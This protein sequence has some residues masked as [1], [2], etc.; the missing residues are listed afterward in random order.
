MQRMQ[1]KIG[2]FL[3]RTADDSQVAILIADFEAADKMLETLIDASKH[4]R[5][6]W[7]DILNRQCSMLGDYENIYSPIVGA[8]N[9]KYS[10]TPQEKLERI[11]ALKAG[12]TELKTEMVE[13]IAMIEKQIV[14]PAKDARACVKTYM[15]VIKKREDKKLDYERYKSRVEKLEKNTKRTDRENSALSKHQM[16]LASATA[17][18]EAADDHLKQTLPGITHA[19]YSLLPHLLNSQIMIQNALLAQL[20]TVLHGYCA[21]NGFSPNPPEADEI[22]RTFEAD[23]NSFRIE[24]ESGIMTIARGKAV[25]QP[26]GAVD[27]GK[28]YTG[29][30]IRNGIQNRR[31]A[32]QT[33]TATLGRPSQHTIEAGPPDA[34]PPSP[35][36]PPPQVNIASRPKITSN[37]SFARSP[38]S[39]LS[40]DSA[41]S[42]GHGSPSPSA[43]QQTDYFSPASHNT[44][45][46]EP[47]RPSAV[48]TTSSASIA[49]IAGKKKPPPPPPPKR[50]ASQQFEYVT[51]LYDYTAQNEGDLNFR[52]GDRI[53]VVKKTASSNDWWEGE[54]RGVRGAFP[55]NYCQ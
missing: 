3:P 46:V 20:Y 48:S 32:S 42:N 6:S 33:K 41:I 35:E 43:Q 49:S 34:N 38:G 7:N 45:Y 27:K 14:A 54:L 1:R 16:D 47:R 8:D 11:N 29:L 51:A 26:M 10:Q 28:S 52:E 15:K 36:A 40:P 55:A 4:W 30:N 24:V 37:T 22:I 19:T 12:Y 50:V 13:E 25:T 18:Y 23:F 31:T 17:A 44:S 2:A 9:D 53:K 39:L 5:D 21:D